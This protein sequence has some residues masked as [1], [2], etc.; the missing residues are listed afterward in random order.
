MDA[1]QLRLPSVIRSSISTTGCSCRRSTTARRCQRVLSVAVRER[2]H[3]D[4]R[5]RRRMG[6][7]DDRVGRG[8]DIL[9]LKELDFPHSLGLLY[10]RLRSSKA[11]RSIRRRQDGW[12]SR[13]TAIP[14]RRYDPRTPRRPQ[15]D[16]SLALNMEYFAYLAEPAETNARS[17]SCSAVRRDRLEIGSR[18]AR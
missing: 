10:R 11:S 14:I 12:A 6:D 2:G 8:R 16:G 15:A 3:P 1:P 4:D 9:I 18:S 17:P 13:R 7:G 5:W